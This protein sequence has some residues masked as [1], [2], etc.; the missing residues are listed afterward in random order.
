MEKFTITQAQW[1][2]VANLPTIK[3]VMQP[4]PSDFQYVGTNRPVEN[5]SW[6]DAVEFC[7]RLSKKTGKSYRLPSETQ[8]EYACRAGTNTPFHFGDTITTDLANYNGNSTYAYAPK[9]HHRHQTTEVGSYPPNAF[10]LYDMHGN[11]LEWCADV[12]HE[13]YHGAPADGS[14]WES[15]GNNSFRLL[16][17]GS[18]MFNPDYCRCASRYDNH[19]GDRFN[20]FG[21][22]VVCSSA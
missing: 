9:G 13:N 12:W 16:R 7:A 3:R 21:F 18:W 14:A 11:V 4:N 6:E 17:G 8:W 1:E 20:F 15:G 19:T 10:G 22:R 2:A 5:L